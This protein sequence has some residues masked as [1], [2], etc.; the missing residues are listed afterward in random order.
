MRE[1]KRGRPP[2]AAGSIFPRDQV[3]QIL[4]EGELAPQPGDPPRRVFPGLRALARR[5][6]VSPSTLSRFAQQVGI[7]VAQPSQ[8]NRAKVRWAEIE[9]LLVEGKLHQHG[10]GNLVLV[11]PDLAELAMRFGVPIP[12]LARFAKQRRCLQRRAALLNPALRSEK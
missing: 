4:L 10:D 2:R 6:G 12:E 11:F 5:Y 9:R 3:K 7:V 8:R 1:R